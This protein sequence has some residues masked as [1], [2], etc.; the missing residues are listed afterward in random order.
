MSR[1]NWFV[2]ITVYI[3][4]AREREIIFLCYVVSSFATLLDGI[5]LAVFLGVWGALIGSFLSTL[6][7]GIAMAAF[8]IKFIKS[9]KQMGNV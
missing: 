5:S 3:Q 2:R 8:Y 1:S 4:Q 6:T 9:H 7:T